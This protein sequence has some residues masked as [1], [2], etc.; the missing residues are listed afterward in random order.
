[1]FSAVNVLPN[2]Q[3]FIGNIKPF[4]CIKQYAVIPGEGSRGKV[5]DE[6]TSRWL[7]W[8]EKYL[9][10]SV[11][12]F[13]NCSKRWFHWLTEKISSYTPIHWI[14]QWVFHKGS[15]GPVAGF[16]GSLGSQGSLWKHWSAQSA[17]VYHHFKGVSFTKGVV[18]AIFS[19]FFQNF[20]PVLSTV[21]KEDFLLLLEEV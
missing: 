15:I 5:T 3:D 1:M 11:P 12:Q 21:A 9:E 19:P 2:G 6:G 20:V 18:W 7:N 10:C 13:P 4:S 16:W 14:G 17:F 8:G